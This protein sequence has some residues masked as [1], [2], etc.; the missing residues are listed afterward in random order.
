MYL[1]AYPRSGSHFF[2]QVLAD[3]TD[4]PSFGGL[5]DATHDRELLIK[6]KNYFY[7]WRNPVDVIFSL[8][9]AE[10]CNDNRAIDFSLLTEEWL[11]NETDSIKK[12][13]EFYWEH[14]GIVVRYNDLI[15][16]KAW[17]EILEFFG[18]EYDEQRILECSEK[19]TLDVSIKWLPSN[20]MTDFMATDEYRQG[21]AAFKEKYEDR[22]LDEFST[23]LHKDRA[24]LKQEDD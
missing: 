8:F 4:S 7:L 12:H 9:S 17:A 11:D 15:S 1:V 23:Y 19:I 22:I 13:F 18:L 5:Y 3:Y 16:D 2:H 6:G 24:Y 20:W 10:F 14:A 21:R